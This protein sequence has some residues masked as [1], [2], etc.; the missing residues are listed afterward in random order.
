MQIRFDHRNETNAKAPSWPYSSRNRQCSKFVYPSPAIRFSINNS[1]PAR[2]WESAIWFLNARKYLRNI[3]FS[4][5]R[6]LEALIDAKPDIVGLTSVTP[7]YGVTK[8]WVQ[9]IREELD[10]PILMGGAHVTALQ[11]VIPEGV[12]I[13]ILNEGEETFRDL[14]ELYQAEKEF[15]PASLA[16]IRGI[17]YRDESGAVLQT[18]PRPFIK[19]IDS[20]PYPAR[21]LMEGKWP[22]P[23]GIDAH[24]L[25]SRGCPHQ[26][27]FC[28]TSR[29]WNNHCRLA[30]IE[31]VIGELELLIERY[32][33]GRINFFDDLF[34]IDH[35]RTVSLLKEMRRR[36]LHKG[37]QFTA[38]IR[39]DGFE[40]HFIEEMAKTN[41]TILNVGLE[42][43]SDRV[44][45]FV[46]HNRDVFFC[47]AFVPLVLLPGAR[48]WNDESARHGVTVE[49]LGAVAMQTEDYFDGQFISDK[50]LYL[51][52]ANIPR[53]E[54][55]Q[56]I[57]MGTML[58]NTIG[59]LFYDRHKV[60]PGLVAETIP[61]KDI[62]MAKVSR[63]LS[64]L[65]QNG[66][67]AP[68]IQG[69]PRL[70]PQGAH[71]QE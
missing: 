34:T 9:R 63:R 29:I 69:I 65:F 46:Y 54:M 47:V 1:T 15:R 26:C 3:E 28:C 22:I 32:N 67:R 40:E 37:R 27:S 25:T 45:N 59:E 13:V 20:I 52:E 17:L 8:N 39:S 24:L 68:A 56:Y 58:G 41:F 55:V 60:T 21:E 12:D 31:Y 64:L 10:C 44:L 30:S 48:I 36:G 53:H 16:K 35:E 61:M 66:G 49:N 4:I 23:N 5:E 7:L 19:N 51:N 70:S 14:L 6:R 57:H 18:A 50:W 71:F 2:H 42:S 11:T 33:P 43:G 38:F 62:F